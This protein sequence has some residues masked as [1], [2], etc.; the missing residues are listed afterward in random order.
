VQVV[1]RWKLVRALGALGLTAFV[2]VGI[3]LIPGLL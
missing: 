1:E 3:G 2:L